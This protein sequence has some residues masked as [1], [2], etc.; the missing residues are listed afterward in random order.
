LIGLS[1]EAASF[2]KAAIFAARALPAMARPSAAPDGR[3]AEARAN[4]RVEILEREQRVTHERH[5]GPVVGADGH[6]VDVDVG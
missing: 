2:A 5:V 6:R 3:F 4:R 1:V